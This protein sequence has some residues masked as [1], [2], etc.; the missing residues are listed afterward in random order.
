MPA[1][2][3]AGGDA[4]LSAADAPFTLADL[5]AVMRHRR[6]LIIR[7]AILVIALTGIVLAMLPTMWSATATILVDQHKNTVA[8]ASAVLT[9][10]VPTDAASMQNQIQILTSRELAGIVAD[11]EHLMD[12]P[13]FNPALAKNPWAPLLDA[14]NPAHWLH[15]DSAAHGPGALRDQVINAVLAN[16]SVDTIGLSTTLSVKFQAKSAADAARIANAFAKAYVDA[17]IRAKDDAAAKAT[18]WL[19]ARVAELANQV[20][21]SDGA[22]AQYKAQNN[23]TGSIDGQ[24][25]SAQQLTAV[26]TQLVQ[27]RADLAAKQA[28]YERVKA[29]IASGHV[30]EVSQIVASP[31]IIQLRTQEA[32]LIQQEADLA[33]R[34]GPLHPRLLAIHSQRADLE[35]KINEEV[36]RIAGSLANDVSVASAQAASLK[37]SLRATQSMAAT[38]SVATVE[39]NALETEAESTRTTY[40]AFVKK[41]REVQDQAPIQ[42]PEAQ[43]LS[44]ADVPLTP[45]SPHRTIL[46]AASIP[47]GFLLGLLAA[48]LAERAAP[49]RAE[50]ERVRARPA[51]PRPQPIPQPAMPAAAA[52]RALAT[53]LGATIGAIDDVLDRPHT[54]FAQGIHALL[55]EIAAPAQGIPPRL[56]AIVSDLPGDSRT[57][58]ALGLARAAA[59]SGQRTVLFDADLLRAPAARSLGYRQARY[60]LL[61]TLYGRAPLSHCFLGDPRTPLLLLANFAAVRE[62]AAILGSDV[63]RRLMG[64]L[65]SSAGLVIADVPPLAS[66]AEAEAILRLADAVLFV[67]DPA[68]ASAE[69]SAATAAHLRKYCA[70][71]LGLILAA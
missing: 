54:P 71:P 47:A 52:P 70:A 53:L 46:F 11:R 30:A 40:D 2:M 36:Q 58:V 12:N 68:R 44:P 1:T 18:Q 43:V 24:P 21:E 55:R 14:L 49:L 66:G 64:H 31:L 67:A 37:D 19:T 22:V 16:L 48:L 63:M 7:I 35:R 60:G 10:A 65:R 45:V 5:H 42:T 41:L 26:N 57:A 39:L 51:A 61:D 13:D 20:Q 17:Q 15:S 34:Y 59:L 9:S 3:V 6:G 23:L 56:V 4:R 62:P 25:L 69:G 38:Q 27:A 8:D 32:Q 29:L 33:A 50:S 28:T